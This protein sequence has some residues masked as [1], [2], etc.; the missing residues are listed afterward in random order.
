MYGVLRPAIEAEDSLVNRTMSGPGQVA[1]NLGGSVLAGLLGTPG[2]LNAMFPKPLQGALPLP[3]SEQLQD[4][5]GVEANRP[6]SYAGLLGAPDPGDALKGIGLLAANSPQF[7]KM[8][9][10]SKLVDESGFPQRL[11]HGSTGDIKRFDLEKANPESDW[12]AGIYLTNSIDDVNANYA[13]FGPDLTQKIEL[14]TERLADEA[15]FASPD[16]KA[17]VEQAAGGKWDDLSYDQRRD[18]LRSMVREQIGSTNEG[19]VTPLYAA[20]DN[21]AIDGGPDETVFE[22]IAEFDKDGEIIGEGGS[23][24]EL[25][26]SLQ[27]VA[28]RFDDFDADGFIGD[29]LERADYESIGLSDL[30]RLA[31]ESEHI[32]HATDDTGNL[33]SAE[34]LR[35]ALEDMGFD[36]IIDN[37][38]NEKFGTASNMAR[39]G[40]NMVGVNEDTVHVIAF[41][42]DKVNTAI[43]GTK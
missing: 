33:V 43:A 18:A 35:Q 36:G 4:K 1:R 12:G 37:R 41:N 38:V 8:F 6:E 9:A 3:T 16:L 5:F 10:K 23:L 14:Q 17:K 31:K 40:N 22:W 26:K 7:A 15:A 24:V 32:M 11:Y 42:P 29:I 25:A 34:V 30:H 27:N 2:D 21:P 19:Q 13:G 20:V 39:Y 28:H